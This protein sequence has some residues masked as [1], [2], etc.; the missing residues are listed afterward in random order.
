MDTETIYDVREDERFCSYE[1]DINEQ[2]ERR[3][4]DGSCITYRYLHGFVREQNLKFSF[5]FPLKETYRGRFF[6]YLSPF[7]GPDE[8]LASLNRTGAD[9]HIAFALRCGAYFVES[10]M[11]S[12]AAFG[13][14]P[15]NTLVWKASAAAAEISRIEAKK[16]Y[17]CERP[18][19]Y[20][21]GGSGGAYKTM[22][23]IEHT[24]AWDG[25]VPYVIG[26][27]VSLPNSITLHALGQR[28][29]RHVYGNIVD[30]LDA[31]GSKNPYEGLT[32][33]EASV[34]REIT[35]MGFPPR[36]WFMEAGGRID[37]GSLPVLAPGVKGMDP[38]YFTDFW[39]VPGYAGADPDG[40]AVRDR[41]C[42]TGKV[43]EVGLPHSGKMPEG[44]GTE[45]DDRNGV[46]TAWKKQL[47]DGEDAWIG[48]EAVPQGEDLWLKG[49]TIRIETGASA[50][51]Q[52]LLGDIVGNRLTI[53]MC[54]GMDDLEGVLGAIRPGDEISLD[55][56][57]Y[58]A[59]QYYYRHQVPADPSFTVFDQFR[60]EDGTP[61]LPQRERVMGLNFSGTGTVQNGNI[62]GKVILLQSMMDE[63]TWPWCA[64][65][66]RKRVIAEKGSDADLRLYYM[67]RCVHGD[68]TAL[69]S[70]MITSY[71]GALH[72]CLLDLSDWV[73]GR[74]EPL[75]GSNYVCEDGQILLPDD[76]GARGGIQPVVTLLANKETCAHVR[77]GEPV[78]LSAKI[79]LPAGAG[80]VTDVEYDFH[81]GM[82]LTEEGHDKVRGEFHPAPE[83]EKSG[84]V[85]E[86][87]CSY[88]KPGVYFAAVH[89][90]IQRNGD[91][92][93]EFTKIHNLARVRIMVEP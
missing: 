53:G 92:L 52:L 75:A 67:D 64:D 85:S 5:C 16:L 15:D 29:L 63:S 78:R 27:P 44:A 69:R 48:L 42:F 30:A 10:N 22:A 32:E 1:I 71:V 89:V 50:G 60:K 6:Q 81:G 25:A 28:C 38:G 34:L 17:G 18:Y 88:E 24:C 2:R 79:S 41:I 21:Y 33:E 35:A 76:A 3:L 31:G 55:N 68:I 7:P 14:M 51:K 49:V 57:D 54:Y 91:V 13:G 9:D 11:C 86:T 70:T 37:D 73:E 8:E 80:T 66:Y 90:S 43:T 46:D 56:S 77:A 87:V 93:E 4:S 45:A 19:G 82:E 23:C 72:Q 12:G 84:A 47:A 40:S 61:A 20:V 62:Q 39:T 58:I 83:G 59:L 26:S 36:A 74:K 65:W